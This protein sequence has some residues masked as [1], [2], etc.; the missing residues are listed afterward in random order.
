MT[1]SKETAS[2][3]GAKLGHPVSEETRMKISEAN[4]GH[5]HTEE[6]KRRMSERRGGVRIRAYPLIIRGLLVE[7][8]VQITGLQRKQVEWLID[9]LKQRGGLQRSTKD[10]EK[11]RKRRAH[12]GKPRVNREREYTL[13]QRNSLAF[14]GKLL[15]AGFFTEDLSNWEKLR[16][17]YSN[18]QRPLPAFFAD[19]LRLEAFFAAR[20]AVEK[21][22]MTLIQTYGNFGNEVDSGWFDSSLVLDEEFITFMVGNPASGYLVDGLG[23]LFRDTRYGPS[24]PLEIVDGMMVFDTAAMVNNRKEQRDRVSASRGKGPQK[25]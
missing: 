3:V 8:I 20:T 15:E 7:D 2:R 11:E 4:K 23:G 5:F 25:A 19:Q 14:A 6:Y 21:G 10:G 12:L 13:E 22:E 18:Y 24:R 16:D 9:D 1:R 17:L